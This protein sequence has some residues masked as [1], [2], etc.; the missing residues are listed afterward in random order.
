MALQAFGIA[1]VGFL[2]DARTLKVYSKVWGVCACVG[3]ITVELFIY[4]YIYTRTYLGLSGL[5]AIIVINRSN[6]CSSGL[7]CRG[8]RPGGALQRGTR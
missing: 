2:A 7:G 8:L 5:I 6:P 1:G 4:I 3:H